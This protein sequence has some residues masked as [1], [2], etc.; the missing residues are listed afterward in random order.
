MPN[1]VDRLAAGRFDTVV[2]PN[3]C[4]GSKVTADLQNDNFLQISQVLQIV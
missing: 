4:Y 1:V 3:W 2:F